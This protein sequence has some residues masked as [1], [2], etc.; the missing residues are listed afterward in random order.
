[1][2]LTSL[3]ISKELIN[4]IKKEILLSKQNWK[5]DL[6]NV[7]ALTSGFN[8]DYIFFDFLKKKISKK[9]LQSTKIKFKASCWWANYY[10]VGQHANLHHHEPEQISSIIFIQTDESNPLYFDLNPGFL[11]VKEEE[12]LIILFDSKLSH[13]VKPCKKPRISLAIDFI[14]DLTP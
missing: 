1:M 13:V 14:E 12:G 8:P 11:N 5:K 4:D 7:K 10:E 2:F 3:S 6:N 9:L